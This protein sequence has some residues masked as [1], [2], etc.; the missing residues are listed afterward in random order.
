MKIAFNIIFMLIKIKILNNLPMIN[1]FVK[2]T[3]HNL[4][5]HYE[6]ETNKNYFLQYVFVSDEFYEERFFH[7]LK[8]TESND[9]KNFLL[10]EYGH[11]EAHEHFQFLKDRTFTSFFRE[12]EVDVPR[13][14]EN[15][16]SVRKPINEIDLLKL[17][18]YLM[19]RGQR[20]HAYK[21][22]SK[23]LRNQYETVSL[24]DNRIFKSNYSWKTIFLLLN[25]GTRFNTNSLLFS[26]VN[27]EVCPYNH[28]F[29]GVTKRI[30][31]EWNFNKWLF[32]N[33]NSLLPIF[34]FYIYKVDKKIFKNTRGKSGKFTFIW[35]Y[36]SV[37]KRIHLVMHWLMKEL[38]LK[39]G[40]TLN[41]RLN[42][43]LQTIVYS[44][45]TTWM[46]KVKKFSHNY[47]YRNSR[48]TLAENYRT[49]TK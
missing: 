29:N 19:R 1:F 11:H 40:R 24:T 7:C 38:K 9:L 8:I 16:L 26:L 41:D 45:N 14:F 34:S 27:D 28:I 44:P 3:E 37:Y 36:V 22:F 48:K 20:I 42:S 6:I 32:S 35:K 39:Q 18:N 21:H 2:N 43:L 15:T 31:P 5:R 4:E 49:V 47:V 46:H 30:T 17:N 25:F 12:N 33:L 23:A 13:C 10:D